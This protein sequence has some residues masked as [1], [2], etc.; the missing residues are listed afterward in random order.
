[1]SF[2]KII[3]YL[4]IL[5]Y[6]YSKILTKYSSL[7]ISSNIVIFES[8][9]FKDNEDM[10]F[11][12]KSWSGNFGEIINTADDYWYD[13]EYVYCDSNGNEKGIYLYYI[14][15]KKT[16]TEDGYDIKYFTIKKKWDEYRPSNG[17]YIK[18]RFNLYDNWAI[19]T[20]T[21][22]DEG[23]IATWVIV[24]IV[25]IV[26]AIIGGM[27]IFFVCRCIRRRKA[28]AAANAA[29]AANA[30][31]IAAQNQA[32]VA[33]INQN[34]YMAEQNYQAQAYQAQIYSAQDYQNPINVPPQMPPDVGFTSKAAI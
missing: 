13:I 32:Y 5:S 4:Y 19:V 16:D 14:N 33:Q 10:H 25:V 21:E 7:E 31:S 3:V 8:K 30:S 29:N 9:D 6:A 27:I 34:A 18:I 1:M 26:V 17:N 2:L 24:V 22:K 28:M 11:K 15:F 12:I 23:K 20:N